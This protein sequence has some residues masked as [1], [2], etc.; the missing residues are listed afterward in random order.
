MSSVPGRG[1]KEEATKSRNLLLLRSGVTLSLLVSAVSVQVREPDLVL[2]VGFQYLYVA[3][4]LSYGWLLT[5]YA[6]WG[7]GEIPLPFLLLQAIVDVA[8]VSLIVFAT[9]LYDSVFAF[10]YIIVILLGSLEMYM[11]GAMIW[12][13]LSAA[14]YVALLYLQMEGFLSPPVTETSH[15]L[16][17]QFVRTSVIN[18]L[19]FI[20][21]GVLSGILG[22]DIRVAR[23]GMQDREST[24]QQ[25][26]T[27]HKHVV[28]NIPSGILTLDTQGRV[29]LINETACFILGVSK[30]DVTG[31]PVE[32]ILSGLDLGLGRADLPMPRPEI[33]FRRRDGTE[34]YLGFSTSPMK[35]ADGAAIGNVVIFQDL[36]PVKQM[37]ERIRI[38]DRLAGVGELAAG[39]AH[40]IR[41]PLASIT[42]S[43]QML[44]ESPDIPVMSRTLLDIIERES[45]RLNGLI[46][47]FLAYAGPKTKNVGPVNMAGMVAEIVEAVLTGEAREKDVAI[48]NLATQNLHVEGD[49]E[50]LN[51]VLWNLVRNAIQATP[52]GGTV[53]IDLFTQIRHRQRF[54][55]TTVSDTGKGIAPDIIGKIFHPFFTSKAEGTGLGLAISQRIVHY[56]RGF[57]EVRSSP[58]A[59]SVFSVFLP[60][61]GESFGGDASSIR[62]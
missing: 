8:F 23:E 32:E 41:N 59:G 34:I 50:Q 7:G 5:R 25:L 24:L 14:T 11:Q 44:R 55:V 18:S 21:T 61:L 49:A 48:E 12:A 1:R 54:A 43:S 40:E 9:G 16:W 30:K 20:I 52:R 26:E 60:E 57:I 6:F 46:S 35:D 2:S 27:F 42:G 39:L 19:G 36:T 29:S 33:V 22:E 15:I 45:T 37:E 53:T 28:E 4:V 13:A 47:D 3:V 56:H 38:A 17:P 62:S 31:M 58:G 10:M 51:Q